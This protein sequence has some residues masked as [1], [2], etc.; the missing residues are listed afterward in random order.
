VVSITTLVEN[1]IGEHLA[2]KNEHGISFFIEKDGHSVLFDAGQTDAFIDNAAWLK[3]DLRSLDYVVLSHGHYDHSGGLRDLVE[4]G[5]DFE[6]IMGTGFFTEKYGYRN[7]SYEYL[8]NNF[9]EGFLT[10]KGIRYRFVEEALSEILPGIYVIG[11]FPR[12]HK[13]EVI[14]PRFKILTE[15]GFENDPFSDEV[16]VAVDSPKGL[17]VI[18]GCSHPGMRNMVDAVKKLLDKPIYA[19]L[20]GT[21]LVEAKGKALDL[22]IEYLQK[23]GLEVIGVSHCT[24]KD[25]MSHLSVSNERYFHNRTGTALIVL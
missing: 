2:L 21:H 11:N 3:K 15:N 7:K 17:I 22:A 14:N 23:E 10:A 19:V 6:L 9:D 20:G 12:I 13:E 16:L 24:G 18:L 8:G 1:S 25:V 5:G 4:L